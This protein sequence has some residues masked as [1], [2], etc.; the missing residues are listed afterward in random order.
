MVVES[1]AAALQGCSNTATELGGDFS[2]AL[3]AAASAS[4]N[5]PMPDEQVTLPGDLLGNH[6][7]AE[8]IAGLHLLLL[9]DT[10]CGFLMAPQ[11]LF[12][13]LF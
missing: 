7:S 1:P 13:A 9:K 11:K 3:A 12:C 5:P 2:L 10:L 8:I 6:T 4:G